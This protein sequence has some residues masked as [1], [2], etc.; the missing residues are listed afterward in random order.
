MGVDMKLNDERAK[1][2]AYGTGV[3]RRELLS[4]TAIAALPAASPSLTGTRPAAYFPPPDSEGGW[5]T[6]TDAASIRKRSGMDLERL[7]QAWEFTQ[8]CCQNAGLCVVRRGYL[9]T[10]KYAGRAQRNVNP[11][12]ASTGKAFTSIACGIM[13]KEFHDKIPNGLDEKVFTEKYLPEAFPLDDPRKADIT[14][15]QLLCMS[16]GYHGEGSSPGVVDGKVVPLTSVPGQDIHNLD[17]SSLR[18]P[19]WTAPG[20]GYS[21]SSPAPH[22]ASMVLRRIT[23]MDLREY[24]DL[25][26]A[27]PMGW[28]PWGYCLHRG[29][30]TMPHSNGAGSIALHS[31]DALRFAYCLGNKGRGGDRQIGPAAYIALWNKPLPNN[32]HTPFSLQIENN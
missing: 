12:M 28:G 30:F 22:I 20:M 29:D 14:L 7:D 4:A 10:E 8:R 11:D 31:T 16:A 17:Q 21:Y 32:T 2:G 13:L 6:L 25:R 15:G 19:L 1:D 23:G 5:R 26:L 24:I 3:T 9:V 27:K 18:T